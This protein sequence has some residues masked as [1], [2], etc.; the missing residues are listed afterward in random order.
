MFSLKKFKE[1]QK[2]VLN[3]FVKGIKMIKDNLWFLH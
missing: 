1:T 3:F 2:N